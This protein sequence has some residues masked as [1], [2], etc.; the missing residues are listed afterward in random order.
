VSHLANLLGV[1]GKPVVRLEERRVDGGDLQPK[2]EGFAMNLVD[3]V[4]SI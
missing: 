4:G 3:P 1:L 2:G